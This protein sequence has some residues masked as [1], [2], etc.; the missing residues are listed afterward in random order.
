MLRP[1]RTLAIVRRHLGR[2][3]EAI[4]I[5]SELVDSGSIGDQL[6][7]R[8]A[9]VV[10]LLAL[11]RADE[12]TIVVGEAVRM[13]AG[14]YREQRPRFAALQASLLNLQGRIT[15]ARD[16]LATVTI[17]D[18]RDPSVVAPFASA[19]VSSRELM[20]SVD[21][22]LVTAAV[23]ALHRVWEEHGRDWLAEPARQALRLLA[24][25]ADSVD[26]RQGYQLWRALA[27]L[28]AADGRQPDSL[29]ALSLAVQAL[30]EGDL[31]QARIDLD[32]AFA[33]IAAGHT[34]SEQLSESYLSTRLLW[35]SAERLQA[36]S[37]HD[38]VPVE[39]QRVVADLGRDV[40]GRA[41]VGHVVDSDIGPFG[42]A[43]APWDEIVATLPGPLGVL[44]WV[45]RTGSRKRSAHGRRR[46]H[47]PCAP[48]R[49]EGR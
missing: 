3:A 42:V 16:A 27:E 30:D 35:S 1:R 43:D 29:A 22:A 14:P 44:E 41:T 48:A 25:L 10:A 18:L 12:A 5:L 23:D 6:E 38:S 45:G 32:A 8:H 2:P 47:G 36:A 9:L 34:T 19:L 20:D 39:Y 21:P 13:C 37:D 17:D 40:V 26:P 4:S 24:L 15:E 46:R 11:G 7:T 49:H 28:S 31:D 33:A